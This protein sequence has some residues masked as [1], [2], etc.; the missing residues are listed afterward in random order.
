MT[1]QL[2]DNRGF[3]WVVPL[4]YFLHI[5]VLEI[6]NFNRTKVNTTIPSMHGV[7]CEKYWKL[8]FQIITKNLNNQPIGKK[9]SFYR[10]KIIRRW[11]M[12]FLSPSK[13]LD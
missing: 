4:W 7:N 11:I 13:K 1:Y 3:Q 10:K 8:D 6:F 2:L 12:I 9:H 5:G